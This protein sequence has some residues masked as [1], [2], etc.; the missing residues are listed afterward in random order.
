MNNLYRVFKKKIAP[1]SN[2]NAATLYNE[3][4]DPEHWGDEEST[5]VKDIKKSKRK[6]KTEPETKATSQSFFADICSSDEEDE[7]F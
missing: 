5:P 7:V 4:E 3:I 1:V 2:R 6:T